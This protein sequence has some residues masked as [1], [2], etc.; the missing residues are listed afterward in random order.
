MT[1]SVDRVSFCDE[2]RSLDKVIIIVS[3][4]E[5]ILNWALH[6]YWR[7]SFT[8]RFAFSTSSI[9]PE[10]STAVTD[11]PREYIFKVRLHVPPPQSRH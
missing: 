5:E 7:V 1:R 8:A 4:F 9:S 10:V 3:F 6:Q 2:E 11:Q